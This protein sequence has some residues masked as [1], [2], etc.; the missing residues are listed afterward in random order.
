MSSPSVRRAFLAVPRERFLPEVAARE[1]LEAVYRNH[2]IVTTRDERGTPMSSSSQPSIMAA[3]LER[4]DLSTGQRVLEVGAGSGYNAALLA[5]LVGPG[6]HVVSIELERATARAARQALSTGDLRARVVQGDGAEGWPRGAPYDRIIVT[7]STRT[8]AH[9]WFEQMGEGGLLTLPLWVDRAGQAQ[10]VITLRK[11]AATMRSVAVILG[12]F[13]PLR[14]SIGGAP[15]RSVAHLQATESID[16]RYRSLA[17]VG[18]G[19]PRAM[20]GDGRRRLLALALSEPRIRQLGMRAPRGALLMYLAVESPAGGFSGSW[21]KPGVIS[22]GGRGL[23]FLAGA[24]TFTR[25]ECHGDP[26]AEQLLLGLIETWK[27]RGRPGESELA[28]EVRFRGKR[29][30]SPRW[31]WPPLR[32]RVP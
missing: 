4:L 11:E 23:A 3:M 17:H 26:Q 22:A 8:V 10:A 32:A 13:M 9:A 1:G 12:G 15:A 28:V 29:A 20:S 30:A 7:A 2:A 31:S 27:Q 14:D 6:G 19:A 24:R 21:D 18:G 16:G 5:E 25:I